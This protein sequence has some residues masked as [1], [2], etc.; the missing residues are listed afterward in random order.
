MKRFFHQVVEI[1]ITGWLKEKLNEI[2]RKL[3]RIMANQQDLDD[4]IA[5]L[6]DQI[7]TTVEAAVQP[8]ID[9]IKNK[10]NATDFAPEI[11]QLQAVGQ[12]VADKV[13]EDLKAAN[14]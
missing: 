2:E 4:A 1:V 14:P 5:A 13:S 8:I 10:P 6:P 9:A 3:N 11:A 12:S 7:K